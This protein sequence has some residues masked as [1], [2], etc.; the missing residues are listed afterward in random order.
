M[1]TITLQKDEKLP[2]AIAT[3]LFCDVTKDAQP[4]DL[5]MDAP[6][7]TIHKIKGLTITQ[8]FDTGQITI[9]GYRSLSRPVQSGYQMDGRVSIDGVKRSAFTSSHLFELENGHLIS[10]AVIFVR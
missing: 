9:Y 2:M 4:F 3:E 7:F 10:V 6:W 8:D 1:K 5:T